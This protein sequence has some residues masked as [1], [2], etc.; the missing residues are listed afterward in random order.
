MPR[1]V[2][3]LAAAERAV[4]A[5]LGV[6]KRRGDW[7]LGRWAAR[8]ALVEAGEAEREADV[9]VLA[10]PS[11]APEAFLLGR[12]APVALSLTHSHGVAV[13]AL[14]PAGVLL[15]VDLERVEARSGVFL[16]DWFTPAEQAF[17]AAGE[18]G[19]PGLAATLVWSAKEA[20]MKALRE[21]LRIPPKA[22]EVA[23]SPGPADGEWRPFDA[24]GPGAEEWRGWWR[25]EEGFVLA[26][27]A[28][29]SCGPPERIG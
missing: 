26:V 12:R 18:A 22:I 3:W 20:V 25:A 14:A 28:R 17:A 1:G 5:R 9:S 6:P 16:A 15:G 10:A 4:L 21:G 19:E 13:A 29:P 8:R 7:L 23:P 27:A 24:R 2:A 11:G